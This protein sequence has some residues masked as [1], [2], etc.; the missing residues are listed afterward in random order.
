MIQLLL[1]PH[2]NQAHETQSYVQSLGRLWTHLY[3]T[4]WLVIKEYSSL[5]EH[6]SGCG[7]LYWCARQRTWDGNTGSSLVFGKIND[8]W[9]DQTT[10]TSKP[11]YLVV[12]LKVS[13]HEMSV[14]SVACTKNSIYGRSKLKMTV[15]KLWFI[16][17]SSSNF[18]ICP[19][20]PP[21]VCLSYMIVQLILFMARTDFILAIPDLSEYLGDYNVT[22]VTQWQ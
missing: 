7:H 3:V 6:G 15:F 19:F 22:V 21:N 10:G 12:K 13:T 2:H 20:C 18:T 17:N 4:S 8:Q 9:D 5:L 11:F 16:T 1:P 14:T